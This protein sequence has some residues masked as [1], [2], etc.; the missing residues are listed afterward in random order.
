[1]PTKSIEQV[2]KAHTDSLMSIEGVVGVA[3]SLCGDK[4][5]MHVMVVKITPELRKKIP[6]EIEGYSVEIIETGLIQALPE[7]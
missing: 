2:L 7:N 5:C 1:M 6:D 3:Q 4:D